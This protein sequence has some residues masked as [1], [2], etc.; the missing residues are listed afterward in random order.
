MKIPFI[1]G[2]PPPPKPDPRVASLL[3]HLGRIEK[4]VDKLEKA[5]AAIRKDLNKHADL[6][7]MRDK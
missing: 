7:M 2:D 4:R 3:K 6:I 5:A 1:F